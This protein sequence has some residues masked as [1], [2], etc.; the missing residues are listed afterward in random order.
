MVGDL[1]DRRGEALP[2]A[3][4]PERHREPAA[5]RAGHQLL[6]KFKDGQI[7]TSGVVKFSA[8]DDLSIPIVGGSGA[9][10]G[11]SGEVGS[12]KPVKGFDSVDVLELEG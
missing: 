12:G 5:G 3:L 1:R 8:L 4:E 7:V 6:H 10:R 2:V 11:A 9:Y